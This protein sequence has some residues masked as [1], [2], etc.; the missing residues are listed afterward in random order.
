MVTTK[1]IDIKNKTYYFYNGLINL[2][3]FDPKLLKLDKKSSKDITIYYIG[4]VTKKK[5]NIIL[6]VQIF[7][8]WLL[9]NKMVLL[10]KKKK[11]NT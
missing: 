10:K 6:I 9:T 5:Q 3:K 2:K 8:I 11:I 7:F 4:Y 1:Q